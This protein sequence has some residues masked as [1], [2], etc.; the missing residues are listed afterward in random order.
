MDSIIKKK[1]IFIVI[2][3]IFFIAGVTFLILTFTKPS[4]L[5]LGLALGFTA[6]ANFTIILANVLFRPKKEIK[7]K[8]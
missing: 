2:A 8:K 1:L 4:N 5:F 6:L 7:T 3:F